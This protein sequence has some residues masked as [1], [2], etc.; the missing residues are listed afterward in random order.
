MPA[1]S[2]QQAR[3][4]YGVINGSIKAPGLSKNKAKEFVTN[5]NIS[6]LPFKRK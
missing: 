1:V 2:K 6:K 4:M 5:V 3:F